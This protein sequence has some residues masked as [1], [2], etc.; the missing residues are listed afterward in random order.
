[1]TAD[2]VGKLALLWRGDPETRR[3]ATPDNNRWRQIFAAMAAQN[4]HAEPAVYC[5]EAADEVQDQLLTVDGVLV[6]VDPLSDGRTRFKLDAMLREIAS[7]GI[8]VSTQ[9]DVTQRMG[10]KEVLYTTRHLGWGT[11]THLYR[12]FGTFQDEFPQRLESDGPRVIKQNRGNGGQGV[13]KVQLASAPQKSG[14]ASV[15]EAQRGSE[16]KTLPLAE[17]MVSCAAYFADGGCIIDQPFQKRLPDGMIRCDMGT[18]KVVG[19]G[20]QFIKALIPPPPEGAASPEAQPGPRIM[21]P[22]TAPEFQAL[23]LKMETEWVPQM[24]ELLDIARDAL[25]IIWD[26]NFLYG[27]RTAAGDDT[28]VLCEINVSSAMPIPEQAPAKIARLARERLA[29]SRVDT[30]QDSGV[31]RA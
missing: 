9:P 28:Y 18:D 20:H 5:E 1:M 15:L 12:S 19:F 27:Q 4:I 29:T 6:W 16:A 2:T 23:R 14:F 17:F 26:A 10:V 22:A 24:M 11:D 31:R 3:Q 7:R 21:H 30:K 25:P 13:W 8:W